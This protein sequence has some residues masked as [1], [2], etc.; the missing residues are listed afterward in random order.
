VKRYHILS[1]VESETGNRCLVMNL[2]EG[3]R[4]TV[5]T[6][7]GERRSYCFAETFIIP[8]SAGKFR[9]VNDTPSVALVVM[10]FVK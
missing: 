10:A 9:I 6:E 5:E 3:T 2:V 7:N 8:A 1:S 4:I